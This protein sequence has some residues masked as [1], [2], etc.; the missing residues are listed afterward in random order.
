MISSTIPGYSASLVGGQINLVTDSR[1][2]TFGAATSVQL[3]ETATSVLLYWL[4]NNGSL[5]F[6]TVNA[7]LTISNAVQLVQT[8]VSTF[9][10]KYLLGVGT[11]FAYVVG[12]TLTINI[13]GTT[14]TGTWGSDRL[15]DFSYDVSNDLQV[16]TVLFSAGVPVQAYTETYSA[17]VKAEAPIFVP[18]SGTY[19]TTLN[20][21]LS[22]NTPNAVIHYTVDGS[23]PSDSSP[24]YTGA[25]H[26][27]GSMTIRAITTAPGYINSDVSSATYTLVLTPQ[28]VAPVFSPVA[29][30]YT[31]A[32]A[33]SIT[34]VTPNRIIRYTLDG[35]DPT[36]ASPIYYGPIS[37]TADTTIKAFATAAGYRPSVIATAVYSI[38][39][40]AP[41]PEDHV[42]PVYS[43][44]HVYDFKMGLRAATGFA[45]DSNV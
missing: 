25:I 26:V 9:Y 23:T 33:V 5:S 24:T 3:V 15:P 21:T 39:I 14:T 7:D 10:A 22:T 28:A 4:E 43:Y 19:T 38:N 32:L 37:V 27:T 44:L 40:P 45:V 8:G 41:T 34:S 42:S 2:V 18:D 6:G 1:A 35:S 16:I 12:T 30:S 29:G 31:T 13:A 36:M 17:Q 20:V 11:S